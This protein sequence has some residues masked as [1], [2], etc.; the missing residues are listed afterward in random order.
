MPAQVGTED[1]KQ[2]VLYYGVKGYISQTDNGERAGEMLA[3]GD[4]N[5]DTY[6]DLVI[7]VQ[8]GHKDYHKIYIVLGSKTL[9]GGSLAGADVAITRTRGR[10]CHQPGPPSESAPLPRRIL[11]VMVMMIWYSVTGSTTVLR[12]CGK[13]CG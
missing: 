9:T 8:N 4:L 11:I 7:V 1:G 13:A 3:V 5:G 2:D 12:C 10:M 6:D